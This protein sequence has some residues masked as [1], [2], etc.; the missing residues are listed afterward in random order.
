MTDFF[1]IIDFFEKE[2]SLEKSYWWNLI[3]E[4]K[5]LNSGILMKF[6]QK[7]WNF[8]KLIFNKNSPLDIVTLSFFDPRKKIDCNWEKLSKNFYLNWIIVEYYIDKNWN[9]SLLSQNQNLPEKFLS[10]NLD[11]PWNWYH[12]S[13]NINISWKFIENNLD[14]PWDFNYLSTRKDLKW[15]T[16]KKNLTKNW[17]WS[18]LSRNPNITWDIIQE[19]GL[20][21]CN[22]FN[23]KLHQPHFILEEFL[24]NPNLSFDIF[25]K[26]IEIFRNIPNDIFFDTIYSNIFSEDEIVLKNKKIKYLKFK[27]FNKI[28]SKFNR[29]IKKNIKIY[30]T[31]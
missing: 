24:S 23:K 28:L 8:K 3:S 4:K 13:K 29:N 10:K 21:K 14:K 31:T 30:F 16:I 26:N 18:L 19:S 22:C 11:K 1:D 6:F 27:I 9:W 5:N 7:K 20:V 17:N 25:Q 12:L 2:K 15:N